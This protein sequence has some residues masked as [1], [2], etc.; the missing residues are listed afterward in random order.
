M[1]SGAHGDPL[2][3]EC[4][5]DVFGAPAVE[6][7]GEHARLLSCRADHRQAGNR[8]HALRRITKQ[9]MFIA[10]DREPADRLDI[11]ERRAEPYRIRDASCAG[12]ETRGRRLIK[13]SRS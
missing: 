12:F 10:L 6:N 9:L 7:E 8:E 4:L 2:L 1:M 3:I 13:R 5:A 11:I